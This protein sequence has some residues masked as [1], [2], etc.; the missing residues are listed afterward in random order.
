MQNVYTAKIMNSVHFKSIVNKKVVR[1]WFSMRKFSLSK[2]LKGLLRSKSK[3]E[4]IRIEQ[5]L[6]AGVTPLEMVKPLS[7]YSRII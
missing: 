3:V 2:L 6:I 7:L 1:G 4:E 5:W